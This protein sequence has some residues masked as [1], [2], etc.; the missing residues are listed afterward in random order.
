ML[1]GSEGAFDDVVGLCYFGFVTVTARI[2]CWFL[3]FT[4]RN[5]LGFCTDWR[6]LL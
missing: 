3:L 2:I 1:L 4:G 5:R 6:F